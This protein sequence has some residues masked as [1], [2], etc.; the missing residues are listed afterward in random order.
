MTKINL[1]KN[2]SNKLAKLKN[3]FQKFKKNFDEAKNQPRSKRKSLFLGFT[4]IISIFGVTLFAPTLMAM[5]K[6]IPKN[7]PKPGGVSPSPPASQPVTLPSKELTKGLA[8]VASTICALAVS[9]G[10]FI[11]GAACGLVV[12]YGIL[13]TQGK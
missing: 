10:S 12:V 11:I 5:A 8:G 3:R 4:T 6:D 13:K 9:S 1:K 2:A 7:S